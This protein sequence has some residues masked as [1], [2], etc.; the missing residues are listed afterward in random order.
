MW[1][2][3]GFVIETSCRGLT[4]GKTPAASILLNGGG[5]QEFSTWIEVYP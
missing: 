5:S 2:R 1:L 3:P 4:E